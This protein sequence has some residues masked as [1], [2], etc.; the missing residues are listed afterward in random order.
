MTRDEQVEALRGTLMAA[1]DL[2]ARDPHDISSADLAER[3]LDSPEFARILDAAR[4]T[5]RETVAPTS[6]EYDAARERLTDI[7]VRVCASGLRGPKA[8]AAV[9]RIH[10]T[11]LDAIAD[12]WEPAES[13]SLRERMA[14]LLTQTADALKGDPGP[15][16][17]HDW[18]D[19][20]E[21]AR[22]VR[23]EALAPVLAPVTGL[24]MDA[25]YYGF[26]ETGVGIIDR[27]LSAV[28]H[29]GEAFHH[30]ENWADER[31]G[32]DRRSFAERIQDVADEAATALRDAARG[33]D[34]Q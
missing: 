18:S 5:S 24:G 12:E 31:R 25:Y 29:A 26:D 7:A 8:R 14:S 9:E 2:Y 21:V 13:V 3:L 6:E 4:A 23:A 30:T 22:E 19:L 33:G 10:G 15:L 16:T 11:L 34:Q 32:D 28:A 1:R 27:I 20:P 17:L